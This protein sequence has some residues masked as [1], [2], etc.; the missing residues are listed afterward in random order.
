MHWAI[1]SSKPKSQLLKHLKNGMHQNEYL[2][3]HAWNGHNDSRN[4][5]LRGIN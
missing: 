2:K 4:R 3:K 1:F 5:F